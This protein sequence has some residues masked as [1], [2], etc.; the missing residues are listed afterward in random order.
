MALTL[1]QLE[2]QVELVWGSEHDGRLSMADV[3]NEAGRYLFD[4][5]SWSWRKRP[6]AS[7][8]F[9]ANQ[10]YMT[11]PED[12]GFGEVISLTMADAVLYGIQPATL[13]E[14][15]EWRQSSLSTSGYL[16]YWA[17]SYPGQI[18]STDAPSF[19]RIELFPT[20]SASESDA[21]KLSYRAGW[22]T[23]TAGQDVA[24]IP[25]P[26]D[27]LLINI[28]RAYAAD[29]AMTLTRPR[30]SFP[31][32]DAIEQS[33]LLNSLKRG[34]GA[35]QS[36]LGQSRGGVLQRPVGTDYGWNFTTE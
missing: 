34:D 35:R 12:F 13:P 4:M 16:Y 19:P 7:L 6:V 15:E 11:L 26:M 30:E 36:N 10:P 23:L 29:R 32:L 22:R 20:P 3:V 9:V 18:T 5:H 28:V 25:A 2:D 27:A 17:L 1:Q 33:A 31:T 8:D 24:S 21:A 14:I